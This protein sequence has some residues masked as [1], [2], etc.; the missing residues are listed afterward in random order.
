VTRI[1]FI[2]AENYGIWSDAK[3]PCGWA[4]CVFV[5]EDHIGVL[6]LVIASC[7]KRIRFAVRLLVL[8]N[9]DTSTAHRHPI[10]LL[11]LRFLVFAFCIFL[12]HAIKVHGSIA[13]MIFRAGGHAVC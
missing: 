4:G 11:G 12:M 1:P 9:G 3:S 2:A 7:S 10:N 5:I 6:R 13:F 8:R